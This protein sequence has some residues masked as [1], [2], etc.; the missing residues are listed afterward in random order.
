M[1]YEMPSITEKGGLAEITAGCLGSGPPDAAEP[2]DI[3]G[4][5]DTSPAFGGNP[6]PLCE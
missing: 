2:Q 1:K 3:E 5:P 4:Y 6:G